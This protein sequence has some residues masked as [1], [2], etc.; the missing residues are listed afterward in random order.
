MGDGE[1]NSQLKT[2]EPQSSITGSSVKELKKVPT[3]LKG[4][5]AP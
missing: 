4:F 1:K 5:A 3:M 2:C